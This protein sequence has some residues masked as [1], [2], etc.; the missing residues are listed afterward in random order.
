MPLALE[1]GQVE[2][3]FLQGDL[4]RAG[5]DIDKVAQQ[6]G[7]MTTIALSF[8]WTYVRTAGLSVAWRILPASLQR[9]RQTV[10]RA[11]EIR[12]DCAPYRA[13][14]IEHWRGRTEWTHLAEAATDTRTTGT[15]RG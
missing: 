7:G 2:T 12:I 14:V 4:Q 3:I 11:A 1:A 5:S 15:E 9:Q 10:R 13:A 6:V 8:E